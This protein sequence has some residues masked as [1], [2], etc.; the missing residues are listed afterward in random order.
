MAKRQLPQQ[1]F[2][3][4]APPP[5]LFNTP[6][7][8]RTQMERQ[9]FNT[10]GISGNANQLL[11][12]LLH[13]DSIALPYQNIPPTVISNDNIVTTRPSTPIEIDATPAR[14]QFRVGKRDFENLI[15]LSERLNDLHEDIRFL[16]E[17]IG[18]KKFPE[19]NERVNLAEVD[20]YDLQIL[21]QSIEDN[22]FQTERHNHSIIKE[23]FPAG[24]SMNAVKRPS[25]IVKHPDGR[26]SNIAV[27]ALVKYFHP[28]QCYMANDNQQ[29][30]L[31][32]HRTVYEFC[33]EHRQYRPH[34]IHISHLCHCP[35][36]VYWKHI[37]FEPQG[38]NLRRNNC[39]RDCVC[40][41]IPECYTEMN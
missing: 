31:K 41:G 6:P 4:Q 9:A 10:Y 22:L 8:I 15:R 2:I 11:D 19:V 33:Q 39:R 23:P 12:S 28:T 25:A 5:I 32:R 20:Q 18:R 27:T 34:E 30:C 29:L 13:I 3:P 37:I 24:V 16:N 14:V 26:R 35:N 40:G 1:S 17:F 36:C 21:Y 38:T 7:D